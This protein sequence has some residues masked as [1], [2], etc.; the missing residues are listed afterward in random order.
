MCVRVHIDVIPGSADV[1]LTPAAP[2]KAILSM[3]CS[4]D[5][6]VRLIVSDSVQE[7]GPSC[8]Y[9]VSLNLAKNGQAFMIDPD[10]L[11]KSCHP[12]GHSI[13]L[14]PA[15]HTQLSSSPHSAHLNLRLGRRRLCHFCSLLPSVFLELLLALSAIFKSDLAGRGSW[16]ERV[17]QPASLWWT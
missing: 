6:R 5:R 8:F 4:W 15:S 13:N 9:G 12:E 1:F 10:N 14:V 16:G 11:P 7:R 17:N 2:G 3:G